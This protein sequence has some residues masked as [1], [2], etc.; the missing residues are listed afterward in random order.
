[1][2]KED[3]FNL[4][5]ITR[6]HGY[7]GAM[8]LFIDA[9]D[10]SV[11]YELDGI[12]FEMNNTFVPFFISR[13]DPKGNQAVIELEGIENEADA[14]ALVNKQVWLPLDLLPELKGKQF[15]FHEIEGFT[16]VDHQLGEI[17]TVKGFTNH[18]TNPLMICDYQG[19]EVFLPMNDEHIIEVDRSA[20]RLLMDLPEGL[21][22][23]NA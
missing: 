15:Y 21:L 6:L 2:Q 20:K 19:S 12:L 9:D 8:M 10:P 22:D 18:P 5:K 3:L 13:L 14:R 16:I 7:K 11:Y 17:G 23:L 4:G 1:M